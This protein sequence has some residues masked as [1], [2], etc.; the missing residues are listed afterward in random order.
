M[1]D[2]FRRFP[3]SDDGYILNDAPGVNAAF[4]GEGFWEFEATEE[5]PPPPPIHH[6]KKPHI[7]NR[8]KRSFG[9]NKR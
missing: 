9:W 8:R 7:I 2:I 4:I 1:V 6:F 5:E 3:S